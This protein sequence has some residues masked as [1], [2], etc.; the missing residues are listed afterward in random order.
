[1]VVCIHCVPCVCVNLLMVGRAESHVHKS[2]TNGW[3]HNAGGV[4]ISVTRPVDQCTGWWRLAPV[5]PTYQHQLN[6]VYVCVLTS[7]WIFSINL[8]HPLR[9]KKKKQQSLHNITFIP[10]PRRIHSVRCT[11]SVHTHTETDGDKIN[12]SFQHI[13][14]LHVT[15]S[16]CCVMFCGFMFI[17]C[18]R[19]CFPQR[20]NGAYKVMH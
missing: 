14:D 20:Q 8:F 16:S 1:M 9:K 3:R 10:W 15:F 5:L 11:D 7:S 17:F 6:K 2:E 12:H 13:H 18:W 4:C 19:S